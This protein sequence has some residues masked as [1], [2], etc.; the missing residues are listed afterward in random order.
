MQGSDSVLECVH[1][2]NS[3]TGVIKAF[4]SWNVP[5]PDKGNVRKNVSKAVNLY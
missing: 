1:E 2:P 3:A 4:M 5:A